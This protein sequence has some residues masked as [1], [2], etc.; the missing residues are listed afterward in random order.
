MKNTKKTIKIAKKYGI[1]LNILTIGLVILTGVG[2]SYAYWQL[3][4]VQDKTNNATTGCFNMELTNQANEIS[5]SNAYPLTDEQGLKL[6]P[7]SFTIHNTCN[8]FAHYYVTVESLEGTTLDSKWIA[9]RVNNEEIKTLD[10]FMTRKPTIDSS[11]S[12]HIISE[13]YLSSED[14]IDYSVSFWMDKSATTDDDVMGKIFKSK[15][16]I[17]SEPGTYSPVEAGFSN[18]NEAILANEYQTTPDNAKTKIAAKQTVDLTNTAPLIKWV[19]KTGSSW[20]IPVSKISKEVINSDDATSNLTENDTKLKLYTSYSFDANTAKYTLSDM[21]Y[22]DPTTLDYTSDTKYYFVNENISYD[23]P[24][25][26]LYTWNSTSDVT[27]YRL[28][29]A[30]L[31]SGITT[32]NNKEY[33]SNDYT[34]QAT[35][36]TEEELETDKSDKGLYQGTDDYGT[37][38]YYRGN[39]K[40]NNVYFAGMYWQIVRINGDGTV[41]LMYN[42]A[43]KNATGEEQTINKTTYAF[44]SKTGSPAYSGYMYGDID[45][46]TTNEVHANTNSSDLKNIVDEWYQN[47]LANTTYETNI[48]KTTGFCG[49]RSVYK[50]GDGISKDK[51]T[52]FGA[53]GRFEKNTAQF[54]CPD[55]NDLYTTSEASLGNKALTYPV[56]LITYDELIYAGLKQETVNKLSYAYS[57]AHY[58]TMSPA[59]YSVQNTSAGLWLFDNAGSMYAWAWTNGS[60][61]IRPV[62]NLSAD[63]KITSGLGTVNDP[64]VVAS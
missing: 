43:V 42:G 26:K 9:T 36:L 59:S 48:A 39:I 62:I 18:L 7:F 12:S 27:I 64:F 2:S 33:K 20:T 57:T 38:Y 29:S 25:G 49:D 46:T 61:G 60:Y 21:I 40:N 10:T 4:K 44:N 35:I 13:G 47:N 3:T 1:M 37:T 55:S 34:L 23:S 52:Y 53:Y 51:T 15:I 28:N 56:G 19:E 16:V 45:G 31:I 32:W 41:R 58:W 5:L 30:S 63:T 17:I 24:T 14:S 11:V 54:T 6:K 50:E 22:A 8:I